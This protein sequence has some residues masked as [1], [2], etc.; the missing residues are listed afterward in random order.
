M[1]TIEAVFFAIDTPR[2]LADGREIGKGRKVKMLTDEQTRA[3]RDEGFVLG[4][5]VLSA[6]A[7]E[8]LQEEVLRVIEERDGEGPRPVMV[9]KIDGDPDRPVWQVVNIWQASGAFKR[10]LSHPTITGDV[11]KL[12]DASE[13]RVWHDQIQ[14]KPMQTGGET[15]WH[16]DSPAWPPLGPKDQQVT[17]WIALDEATTENGCMSMVVGSHRWGDHNAYLE[18]VHGF[19][20][21][22]GEHAGQRIERR[23]CPVPRGHIHYHHGLTWHASHE[24]RSARPRRAIAIHYMSEKTCYNASGDH[25]MKPF[26]RV[27]DGEALRGDSFPLVWSRR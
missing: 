11:A 26:V 4:S 15:P 22:P 3:F 5:M 6:D 20:G 2:E 19:E 7:I 21:L 10:L 1:V 8:E 9:H 12:L 25:V 14:Y 24:N 27:A 23:A 16:Q 18:T 13:L 17:A